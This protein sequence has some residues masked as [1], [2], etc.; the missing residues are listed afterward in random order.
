LQRCGI[1]LDDAA[2]GIRH[3]ACH[4]QDGI[5]A[6]D[7]SA[8]QAGDHV[9]APGGWHD[10]GDYGKYVATTAVAVGRLLSLYEQHP[11]LFAD[12]HLDIPESGNGLPDLLDEAKVGLDWM[13]AMQRADGAVYRKLS[14]KAW[15]HAIPPDADTQT[16]Y[17]YGITTPETAKAAA[18]FAMAARIYK[19]RRPQEAGR[20]L[21]AARK[22]WKFLEKAPGQVFDY[23]EGDNSGSGPYML[24][25]TDIEESLSYDWDD[26]LWAAVEL[27]ITTGENRWGDY[28]AARMPEAPLRI[29]EWK[30]P[31]ALAMED[32]LFH[33]KARD[34]RGLREAIRQKIISRAETVLENVA[35][36]GYRI[37]NG[38]FIWSSNKMTAEEGIVLLRA[39]RLTGK[40][41]YL[42]A[43]VDQLD[44]L[45]GRNHFGLSFAS[46]IGAN[47]VAH[48]SHIFARSAQ[49]S[50]PGL[51]VGGPNALEQSEIGPKFKGP[52]SYIDDDRSY[53]TNEYAIDYNASFIVLMGLAVTDGAQ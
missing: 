29:F 26:R 6:H 28:L 27:Y 32:Y 43:A 45:L 13:L 25:K 5:V 10:A 51:F 24:N 17:L 9:A 40:R 52:L 38:R 23:H 22:A 47:P 15:P 41:R 33:P 7:D 49:I 53:A 3:A 16:R 18:A 8:H 50:I 44:Y 35:Y 2:T 42:E 31:T 1:A 48:V 19:D 36:S 4:V 46:A 20:Y 30:N 12:G 11:E 14:G 39:Y 34:R 21:E 37:A